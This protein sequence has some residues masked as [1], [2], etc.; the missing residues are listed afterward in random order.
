MH[1]SSWNRYQA[2]A[3]HFGISLVIFLVLV[4]LVFTVWYPG[5]LMQAD[6]SWEQALMMIAGVDLVLGPLLTLIVFNPKKKSL[7]MD[8]SIIALCQ[9]AALVAGLYTVN[10]SRPVGL[11]LAFPPQGFEVLYANTVTPELAAFA[12]DAETPLFYYTGKE[13]FGPATQ[14][15]LT[16]E[17]LAPV[18]NPDLSY[19]AFIERKSPKGMFELDG[20]LRMQIAMTNNW[21][22]T[23]LD[24]S[25]PTIVP[26]EALKAAEK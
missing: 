20:K 1:L 2:F 25:E 3:A 18:N 23:N 9:L 14:M 22:V 5:L 12:E 11:Y 7:K 17:M 15:D 10:S 19:Q 16:P 8:L 6:N 13:L 21:I 26:S 4:L 24:G